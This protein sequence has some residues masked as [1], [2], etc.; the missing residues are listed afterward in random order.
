M[1]RISYTHFSKSWSMFTTA[2]SIKLKTPHNMLKYFPYLNNSTFTNQKTRILAHKYLHHCL[3]FCLLYE[4]NPDMHVR[5]CEFSCS[6]DC[7]VD[8]SIAKRVAHD[9]W[10][11]FKVL[12]YRPDIYTKSLWD[13]SQWTLAQSG[14]THKN[15]TIHMYW[16]LCG[17]KSRQFKL[18][19]DNRKVKTAIYIS[20]HNNKEWA[21]ITSLILLTCQHGRTRHSS[22][23]V[24]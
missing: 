20:H 3:V 18:A 15:F 23:Q 13:L 21:N 16:N 12:C 9:A 10:T 5:R 6:C 4:T 7:N 14:L 19:S 2:S 17:I 8:R 11:S 1:W 22:F 24:V